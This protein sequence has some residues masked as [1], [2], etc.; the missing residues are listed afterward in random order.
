MEQKVIISNT[1]IFQTKLVKKLKFLRE[2]Y[3]DGR[4]YQI[5]I[6]KQIVFNWK[7]RE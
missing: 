3:R 4:G 5:N 1:N 6:F 7:E 2:Y